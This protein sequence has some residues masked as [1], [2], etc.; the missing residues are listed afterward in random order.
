MP[1]SIAG[2]ISAT[3]LL[4]S[5]AYSNY[6]SLDWLQTNNLTEQINP[7][8]GEYIQLGGTNNRLPVL[9]RIS[10]ETTLGNESAQLSDVVFQ[11]GRSCI[12][13]R[14]GENNMDG[15]RKVRIIYGNT[16]GT[17]T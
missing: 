15:I 6:I 5:G 16:G 11:S 10:L 3:A 12:I 4:D 7:V 13:G 1:V 17:G 2:N 9:G 14:D 8:E